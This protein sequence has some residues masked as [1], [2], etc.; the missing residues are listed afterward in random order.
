[1]EQ[2]LVRTGLHGSALVGLLAQLALIEQPA[3]APSFVEGMGRWLGWKEAIPLSAVLQQAA[4]GRVAAA[5]SAQRTK[6]NVDELVLE[7]ARVRSTLTQAILD[8]GDTAH[9]DGHDFLPFRRRCFSLQQ[10]MGTAVDPLRDKLR[11]AVAQLSPPTARLAALDAVMAQ[12]LAPREQTLLAQLP[13][14]LE[15]HFMRLR[16][17]ESDA[18]LT[19]PTALTTPTAFAAFAALTALTALTAPTAPTARPTLPAQTPPRVS[20]TH[21]P[22]LM[23]L[24]PVTPGK[25]FTPRLTPTRQ[26]PWLDTFC[27]VMQ[28]LLLAELDLRLQPAQG[29]LDTLR[30][31]VSAA[32]NQDLHE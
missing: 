28:S 17:A 13:V 15:K 32:P 25:P 31:V 27:Q 2:D 11:A 14:L 10:A 9:E 22:P 3:V 5:P 1:M 4:P 23:P 19:A 6:A 12:A 8:Q 29:L 16:Q 18:A 30:S 21:R 26:A 20:K 24:M 7:W